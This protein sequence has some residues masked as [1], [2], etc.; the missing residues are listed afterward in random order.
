MNFLSLISL[1]LAITGSLHVLM[2][3]RLISLNKFVSQFSSELYIF[4]LVYV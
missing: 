2:H 4:L 1:W 3:A